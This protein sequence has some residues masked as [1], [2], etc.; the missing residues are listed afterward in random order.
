ML[1]AFSED[2]V[3]RLIRMKILD[4]QKR[5]VYTYGME[6]LLLNG[7]VMMST[8]VISL[9]TDTLVHYLFFVMVFCPLRMMAGGY[10]AQTAGKCFLVSNGIYM[11]T[12]LIRYLLLGKGI[13]S[14]WLILGGLA[15]AGMYLNGP[16]ERETVYVSVEVHN[17]H[18]RNLKIILLLDLILLICLYVLHGS[19]L[20]SVSMSLVLVKILQRKTGGR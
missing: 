7:G 2:I 4:I 16:I 3:Y 20:G 1:K 11:A 6:V 9:L 8:F 18:K 10:H 15:V 17:R 14:I 19:Y 13:D 12:V 5:E